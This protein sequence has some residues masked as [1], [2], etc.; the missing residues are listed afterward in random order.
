VGASL[1]ALFLT[2]V[3][4]LLGASMGAGATTV[5]AVCHAD[6]QATEIPARYRPLY[7]TAATRYRLG[8]RGPAILASIHKHESGFGQN[9][10]PS[11]A[12]AIGHMQFM[13]VTWAAYGVDANRDGDTDP[14]N[15]EDAIHGAANYLHAS[16]APTNWTGALFAYNHA[17]WYARLILDGAE[18]FQGLCDQPATVPA[19]LGDL[20][21][22]PLERIIHVASWI[23]QGRHPYCW[24]GG[25]STTPGP[26]TGSYCWTSNGTKAF[27]TSETGLDCSGAVRWLLV[28]AGYKDPGGITSG[29]FATA[30]PS[31]PG[32]AATIWS[33][34]NHVFIHIRGKGFSGTTQTNYRHGPGWIQ[35]YPTAGFTASH[36]PRL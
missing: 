4:L 24:G 27:G 11:S 7:A 36:P 15:A 10:G 13:P 22:D 33:N 28:L 6:G 16:G 30:Y 32:R 5:G 19:E 26:S 31:G 14:S 18:G 21:A 29:S 20:P 12:G 34:A 2:A 9:M 8:P 23:D 25:H 1:T 3:V 35:G 17:D